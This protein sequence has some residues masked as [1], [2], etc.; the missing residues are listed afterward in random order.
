MFDFVSNKSN[1]SGFLILQSL[2]NLL[3]SHSCYHDLK[4]LLFN[5]CGPT[6]RELPFY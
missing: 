1:F 4:K 5:S 3:S 2:L 6:I